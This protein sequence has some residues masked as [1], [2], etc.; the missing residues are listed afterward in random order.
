MLIFAHIGSAVAAV[1]LLRRKRPSREVDYRLV[2]LLSLLPD[3]IDKP[4]FALFSSDIRSGKGLAHTVTFQ[5]MLLAFFASRKGSP[6]YA[7]PSLL[8]VLVDAPASFRAFWWPYRSERGMGLGAM[9]QALSDWLGALSW[10]PRLR[11]KSRILDM[12]L[13]GLRRPSVV[14]LELAGLLV[15]VRAVVVTKLYKRDRLVRFVS[16][17][18]IGEEEAP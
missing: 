7:L 9:L 5:A 10:Q 13:V 17:G 2:A 12:F 6:I 14:A 11:A 18:E 3:M 8:H 16:T 15:L 4:L 1:S